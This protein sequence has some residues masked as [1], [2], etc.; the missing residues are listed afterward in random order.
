MLIR[1]LNTLTILAL[2]SCSAF[3]TVG[4]SQTIEVL[5][6]DKTE[7]KVYLLRHFEDGRG[8]LPQLYYYQFNQK[9]TEPKLIEVKSIYINPKTRKVDYDQDGIQFEKDLNQIKKRLQPLTAQN[10]KG[11]QLHILKKTVKQV[12]HIYEPN[13]TMSEY[14]YQYQIS[15]GQYR[16]G[17]QTAVSYKPNL[18][19][20]QAFLIPNQ[21]Y[22][23]V[24]TQYLAF[25]E[26]TGYTTET[27]VLLRKK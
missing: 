20:H 9:K 24:S 22:K 14:R 19:I 18:K 10:L 16:S 11:T 12:P 15:S 25:P 6:Y 3:A 13:I 2:F 21:P 8:R 5:G 17:T 1:Q 26:E 4:G 7:Q 23:M 27:P